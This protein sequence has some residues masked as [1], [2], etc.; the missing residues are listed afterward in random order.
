MSSGAA[1][2]P[3]TAAAGVG[4]RSRQGLRAPQ[5]LQ[6]E[7]GLVAQPAS[8]SSWPSRMS[9]RR[10]CRWSLC[11]RPLSAMR[12][13]VRPTGRADTRCPGDRCPGDRCPGVRCPR[14]WRPHDRGDPGVRTARRPVSTA[15]AATRS[16][17]RWIPEVGAAGPATV[18]APGSTCRCGRRAAWSWLPESGLAGKGWSNVGRAWLARASTA[19]LAAAWQAHRLRRRA[20]RLADPGAGPAPGAGR[21]A[22]EQGRAGAHPSPRVSILD[23][24]P[25]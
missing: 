23:R 10:P 22:R 20:G 5:T 16:A 3:V 13:D 8:P 21:L 25:A 7:R 15:A 14:D 4:T 11:P 24:S 12:T 18:G 9:G 1:R 2:L 19:S 17:P 6:P